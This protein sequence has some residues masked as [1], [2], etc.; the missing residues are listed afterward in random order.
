MREGKGRGREG[1]C[2][3]GSSDFESLLVIKLLDARQQENISRNL[4]WSH[5]IIIVKICLI[6]QN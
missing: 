6:Y 2:Y 3:L 5:E 4:Y 1:R